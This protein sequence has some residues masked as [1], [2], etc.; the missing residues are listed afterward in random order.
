[1]KGENYDF[2]EVVVKASK[3]CEDT[4][5]AGGSEAVVE[6][7]DFSWEEELELLRVEVRSVADQCRKDETK[8]MINLIEVSI[9][10]LWWGF[11]DA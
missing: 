2:A 11:A 8:K 7:T 6:G 3:K 9:C 10:R 5:S 4:F 1:L